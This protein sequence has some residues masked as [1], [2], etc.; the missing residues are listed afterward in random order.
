[1]HNARAM[2]TEQVHNARVINTEE[3]H[4]DRDINTEQ[5]RWGGVLS[6]TFQGFA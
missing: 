4:N 2:N 1:M 5:P 6:D 3:V